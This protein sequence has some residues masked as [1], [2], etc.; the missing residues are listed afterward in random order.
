MEIKPGYPVAAPEKSPAIL[1]KKGRRSDTVFEVG[2]KAR[3]VTLQNYDIEDIVDIKPDD[4]IRIDLT[5]KKSSRSVRETSAIMYSLPPNRQE[6]GAV[7]DI[8]A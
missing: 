1:A 7:I 6:K 4:I 2:D 3:D 8:W 5:Y